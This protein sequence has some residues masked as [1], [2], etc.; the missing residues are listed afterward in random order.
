MPSRAIPSRQPLGV[1][2]SP[3]AVT[4]LTRRSLNAI[5]FKWQR[6]SGG[7]LG[8]EGRCQI[9]ASRLPSTA[10]P[11]ERG[12]KHADSVGIPLS[13]P[14]RATPEGRRLMA[15]EHFNASSIG[16]T[17][18]VSRKLMKGD[19]ASDNVSRHRFG[20]IDRFRFHVL[21]CSNRISDLRELTRESVSAI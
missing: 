1:L 7:E 20:A 14:S 11:I 19:A 15:R 16:R 3:S 18:P 21:V 9:G 8:H 12:N 2:V 5:P 4:K 17:R 13:T 10:K 6:S